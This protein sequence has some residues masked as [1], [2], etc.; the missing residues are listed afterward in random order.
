M[1]P[2]QRCSFFP[3]FPYLFSGWF[4]PPFV[5][6]SDFFA[7]HWQHWVNFLSSGSATL[8]P[9]SPYGARGPPSMLHANINV[10]MRSRVIHTGGNTFPLWAKLLPHTEVHLS[11]REPMQ[12]CAFYMIAW[13]GW[14]IQITRFSRLTMAVNSHTGNVAGDSQP[15]GV[16][17]H[18]YIWLSNVNWLIPKLVY[19]KLLLVFLSFWLIVFRSLMQLFQICDQPDEMENWEV[20]TFYLLLG[21]R[22]I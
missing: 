9:D 2:A 15:E 16:Q 20:L 8:R 17:W 12:K 3:S 22:Q 14:G 19:L 18:W 1:L 21:H 13:M 6:A 4:Q 10:T 7:A 11:H 5:W